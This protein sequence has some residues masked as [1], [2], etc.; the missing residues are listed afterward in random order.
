MYSLD[1]TG[2]LRGS[3]MAFRI[4]V[5]AW[6]PQPD[7]DNP[8][9]GKA[10]PPPPPSVPPPY[11]V[12]N[13]VPGFGFS[14]APPPTNPLTHPGACGPRFGGDNFQRPP[15]DPSAWK[16]TFRAKQSF[17]FRVGAF[18]DQPMIVLNTGV[19]PGTT[20]VLTDTR[21]NNGSICYSLTAIVKTSV[22]SVT[23][24][25]LVNQYRVVL[26]AEVQDP[27]PS[28]MV[29]DLLGGLLG[30]LASALTPNLEWDL[31]LRFSATG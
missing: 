15:A 7:V 29:S 18:G 20:T 13:P 6:I 12:P 31:D 23:W 2:R 26:K 3:T 16:D 17:K 11:P 21:E 9:Y 1:T 19:V 30:G 22:A 10:A 27:V 28:T 4:D 25:A 5:F 8:M 14:P 24:L